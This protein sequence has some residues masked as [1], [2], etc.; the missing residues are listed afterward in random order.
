MDTTA[1]KPEV[2][3]IGILGWELRNEGTLSQFEDIPGNVANPAAFSFPVLYRRVEGAYYQTVVVQPSKK[4]LANM[5]ET[6]REME[7]GG[8]QA[9][10]T[11][12]GFNAIFQRELADAVSV[13]FFA[14]SLIQVPLVYQMLKKGQ[15]VGIITADKK[16]LTKKHLE[17]AGISG[18]I[19]V[20]IAGIENT[21]EFSKVRDDSKADLDIDKFGKEIVGV[22][23]Q[24]INEH[25]DV[26]AVVLECT[27]LPPF[28]AAIRREIGLPVFDIVTLAHM[29]YESVAG[30]RW[31]WKKNG[32]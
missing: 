1:D 25:R 26:G 6:T 28:A 30:D 2:P 23:K 19:P 14:S 15:R 13:P 21:G 10:M 3:V 20:C 24:L 9:I 17:N 8:I 31:G 7:R 22:S 5:I 29:V 11:N 32:I 12:C 16:Y 4:V 27:D 18:E